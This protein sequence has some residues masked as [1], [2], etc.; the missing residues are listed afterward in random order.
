LKPPKAITLWG[1]DQLGGVSHALT[2]VDV[3]AQP[4]HVRDDVRV[5]LRG[6]DGAH[7][8]RHLVDA[9]VQRGLL[10]EHYVGHRVADKD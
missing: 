9:E 10:A 7:M 3:V 2:E 4:R 6:R 1:A 5:R 8:V